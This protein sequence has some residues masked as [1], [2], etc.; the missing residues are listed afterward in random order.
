MLLNCGEDS[1]ESLNC[2]GIKLVNSNENQPQIFTGRTDAEAENPILWPSDAKSWLNR[3]DPVAGKD[4]R[5][6]EKG[7]TEN[8]MVGWRQPT[9]W[10]WVWA[11]SRRCWRT[12]KPG[13]LQFTRSQRVERD[14][15][16]EHLS[17]ISYL[18]CE[19]FR[20][21]FSVPSLFLFFFFFFFLQYH[22]ILFT[23][24]L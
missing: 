11:G 18:Y 2:Q 3:K 7:T 14:W 13:M 19:S 21:S 22:A 12:G 10:T 1:R 6:E 9:Q 24:A 16:T 15:A 8:E 5:H 23:V 20:A 17:K 4:W